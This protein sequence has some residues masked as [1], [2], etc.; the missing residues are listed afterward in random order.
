M[1]TVVCILFGTSVLVL[2][3]VA[4]S[5]HKKPKRVYLDGCFD[6]VHCGHANAL[7]QARTLGDKLVVG[8]NSDEEIIRNKGCP[9]V[10]T[11][12]ERFTLLSSIKW[13]DEIID[14]TP[15]EV[16][17]SFLDTLFSTHKVDLVVHGDDPCYL[18]DGSDA[19]TGAKQMNKF[20]CVK[21]TE[22]V[23]TTEIIERMLSIGTHGKHAA[24][25]RTLESQFMAT[26][27][28]LVQF[29][30]NL[31]VPRDK[32]VVYVDG[33]FD[34]FHCG[35]VEILQQARQR[36][37]FVL[38]GIHSDAEVGKR[39]GNAYPILGLYERTLS[40]LACKYVD[41]VIIGAPP[42]MNK[43]MINTFNIGLVL[44]GSISE[45][46]KDYTK[47][48]QRYHV[49]IQLQM[50]QK[51]TSKSQM[52]TQ[53]LIKRVLAQ[54]DKY[55]FRNEIKLPSARRYANQENYVEEA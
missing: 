54:Q 34:V 43:H 30:N 38:V 47:S 1:W 8:L 27:R 41:E 25:P 24:E 17:K 13:V 44:R 22:G 2:R 12:Q 31:K 51:I 16:N 4:T 11:Q 3:K 29:S 23:S 20:K 19:Y 32:I 48:L 39:R 6:F 7:R 46:G 26:S 21:R 52:T 36:G 10:L 18:Q 15:Y 35:H 50:F 53:K 28:R 42:F 49:P 14:G 55:E 33:A 40:V 45:S 37:D 9:P 5:R